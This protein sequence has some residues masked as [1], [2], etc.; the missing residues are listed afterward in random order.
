MSIHAQN[1]TKK[2]TAAGRV[3]LTLGRR[4]N[5]EAKKSNYVLNTSVPVSRQ[6]SGKYK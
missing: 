1:K 5:D 3:K 4:K 2:Q 6:N